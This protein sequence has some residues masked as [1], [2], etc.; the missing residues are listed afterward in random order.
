MADFDL[1]EFSTVCVGYGYKN[2]F[3]IEVGASKGQNIVKSEKLKTL[4][5]IGFLLQTETFPNGK[6]K[7]HVF[8]TLL[9]EEDGIFFRENL[10]MIW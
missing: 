4:G 7:N 8:Y 1:E 3:K 6:Y 9:K 5:D 10:N 2:L